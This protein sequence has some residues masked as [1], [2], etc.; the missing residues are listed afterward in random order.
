MGFGLGRTRGVSAVAPARALTV[1][2]ACV[3]L[4]S[5]D[6]SRAAAPAASTVSGM[7]VVI[8]ASPTEAVALDPLAALDPTATPTATLTMEVAAGPVRAWVASA[9][10]LRATPGGNAPVAVHLGAGFPVALTTEAQQVDGVEWRKVVWLTSG[11]WGEAWLPAASLAWEQ[12]SVIP[13]AGL[14]ALS[15]ELERYVERFGSHVGVAVL[16][17]TRGRT[18]EYNAGKGFKAASSM[19]VPIML[20][21]LSQLEDAR[22]EPT[23]KELHLLTLMIEESNNT[24]A[25]ALYG[26]IHDR[27]G[28][29]AYLR[30]IGVNGIAATPIANGF[31]YSLISPT[32]MVSLL[33]K[34]RTGAALNPSHTALALKLMSNIVPYERIGVGDSSPA[35]AQVAMKDGWVDVRDGSHTAVMNSSGIVTV[36]GEVFLVAVYTDGLHHWNE[37]WTITRNVCRDVGVALVSAKTPLAIP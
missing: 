24:A 5:C 35:G 13:S 21:F 37:G 34:L 22:R 16:D 27:A 15:A 19:K 11:A 36:G 28:V 25:Y 2:L 6:A 17:V 8:P 29:T 20:A 23:E 4:W 9:V 7:P 12:P 30:K 1:A 3:A 14:D 18:Y 31:G 10:A 32:A 33:D 26:E